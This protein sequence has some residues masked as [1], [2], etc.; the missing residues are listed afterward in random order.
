MRTLFTFILFVS[1]LIISH[2]QRKIILQ[3]QVIDRPQ[4]TVMRIG[5]VG[6]EYRTQAQTFPIASDGSFYYEMEI[7]DVLEYELVFQSEMDNGMW[8]PIYFFT[9]GDKISF[10]LYPVQRHDENV[11][12]GSPMLSSRLAFQRE[13]A[14]EMKP[15]EEKLNEAQPWTLEP[16]SEE[17]NSFQKDM[18]GL[19]VTVLTKTQDR[20]KS[21]KSLLGFYEYFNT[22]KSMDQ[23]KVVVD[24]FFTYGKFWME[25]FPDHPLTDRTRTF[26]KAIAQV[27][28]GGEY[29]E[30]H[31]RTMDDQLTAFGDEFSEGEENNYVLLDLWAPW[32]GP[33]IAKS[34]KISEEWEYLSSNSLDVFSVVGGVDEKEKA[35]RAIEKHAYSWASHL[36]IKE[37]HNIWAKY[38]VSGGGGGQFLY[39]ASGTL[40]AINPSIDELK[41]L[42]SQK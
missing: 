2:A 19:M 40:V 1:F 33:C 4:D 28:V 39:D 3:G 24:E 17:W 6:N 14:E 34:K 9:D 23:Q 21:E 22:M 37:E 32:C 13:L 15:H 12:E 20:F 7:D 35:I 42:V 29:V 26:L 8:K 31:T 38:G 25:Q 10:T 5:Q 18:K 16:G 41:E 11:V 30:F 36:E 27:K